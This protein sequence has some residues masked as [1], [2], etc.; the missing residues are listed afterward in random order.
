MK[1]YFYLAVSTFVI[2]FSALSSHGFAESSTVYAQLSSLQNQMPKGAPLVSL[3]KADDLSGIDQSTNSKL[4]IKEAGTYFVMAAGQAGV[5]KSASAAGGV[6]DLW[7]IKNNQSIPNSGVRQF[8]ALPQS[9]SVIVSQA[10][11]TLKEGDTLSFGYSA[12]KPQHGLIAISGNESQPAIP[13]I[14]VSIYK[15]GR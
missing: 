7:L 12:N 6:V 14:I 1:N 5:E 3:E 4:V 11:L 2:G 9:T 8:L 13:S 15:I 10:I